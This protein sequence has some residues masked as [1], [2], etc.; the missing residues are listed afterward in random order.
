MKGHAAQRNLLCKPV[1]SFHL[2]PPTL[3]ST[4]SQFLVQF[5]LCGLISFGWI[6]GTTSYSLHWFLAFKELTFKYILIFRLSTLFFLGG[7]PLKVAG[8][9]YSLRLEF[10]LE[11]VCLHLF[12]E[13]PNKELLVLN[14]RL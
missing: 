10:L 14:Q 2:S 1:F 4:D 5:L 11:A 13:G 9:A 12:L 3:L 6:N 7:Q 8:G